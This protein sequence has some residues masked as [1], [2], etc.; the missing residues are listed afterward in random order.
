MHAHAAHR[1]LTSLLVAPRALFATFPFTHAP[2]HPRA[3]TPPTCRTAEA[4]YFTGRLV[5]IFK[6]VL[7]EGI[8]QPIYLG[9]H[10][11]DYMID[12]LALAASGADAGASQLALRQIELNTMSSAFAGLSSRVSQMHAFLAKRCAA[13]AAALMHRELPL[14]ALPHNAS[15]VAVPHALATAHKLYKPTTEYV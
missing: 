9:I 11:S 13:E 6:T 15:G 7:A 8:A 5:G 2:T 10:R 4:D 14:D 3:P 1:T 12:E